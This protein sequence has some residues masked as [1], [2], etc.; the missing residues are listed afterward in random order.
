[1]PEPDPGDDYDDAD[2][3]DQDPAG[4]R[5]RGGRPAARPVSVI[6]W[7]TALSDVGQRHDQEL[8]STP[9]RPAD[10]IA[11]VGDQV[12]RELPHDRTGHLVAEVDDDVVGYLNLVP[13]TD[14]A[15]AMA[16]VAVHPDCPQA[17][18]RF[19]IDPRGPR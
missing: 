12:L 5:R 1:M 6:A 18:D 11:P 7:R 2:A 19:G 8:S 3:Y 13:A 9:P 4:F 14:D 16:E 17:R 10:G 15:P